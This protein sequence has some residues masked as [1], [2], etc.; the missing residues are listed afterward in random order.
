MYVV[1]IMKIEM[2][3]TYFLCAYQKFLIEQIKIIIY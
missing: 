2:L 3:R 1:K